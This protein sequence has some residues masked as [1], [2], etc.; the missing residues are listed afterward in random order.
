[1]IK[2]LLINLF[3]KLENDLKTIC[4]PCIPDNVSDT[5]HVS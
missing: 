2:Y 1:M 5:Y 4:N 3:N